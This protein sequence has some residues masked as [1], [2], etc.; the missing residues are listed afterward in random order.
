MDE[1]FCPFEKPILS[2]RFAC[3]CAER[4]QVGERVVVLCREL[5]AHTNCMT[6]L[7]LLKEKARFVFKLTQISDSLPFGKKTKVLYGGLLGLQKAMTPVLGSA[8]TIDNIH[9]LIAAAKQTY[10]SLQDLPYNE[11]IQSISAYQVK[12][13]RARD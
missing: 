13:R 5:H 2:T 7:E 8:V 12:R 6:I 3:E 4:S 11:I 9:G 10:G 1:R